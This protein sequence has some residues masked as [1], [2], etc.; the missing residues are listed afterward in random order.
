MTMLEDIAIRRR[1]L[2]KLAQVGAL[3]CA[4]IAGCDAV[5]EHSERSP[6]PLLDQHS[7]VPVPSVRGPIGDVGAVGHPLW[8]SWYDLSA[9][10][11]TEQEYFVSGSARPHPAGEPAPYTT[12]IIVRRPIDASRFNGTVLLDWV[13]VT[14]GFENAVDTIEAEAFFQREGFAYVHV[15][16]Q[17]VGICCDALALQGWDP[18]RYAE[19][20][21]PGD[22]Y[23]F[24]IFS[25]VAQAFRAPADV[26]P[27]QE[28]K[29][30]RVLAMGQSQ[31]ADRLYR[32]V[33]EVQAKSG[34]IDGFLIHSGPF[35]NRAYDVAP[36]VPVVQLFSEGEASAEP[37][38]EMSNYRGW[39]IAGSAH[40][41]FWVGY[42][43][44]N[45]QGPRVLFDAPQQSLAAVEELRAA[46]AN[47]GEQHDS[48][49]LVCIV[50][51][52]QF[53]MRYVVAAALHHL[54]QWVETGTPPPVG[55]RFEYDAEGALVRD[56]YGN[57]R[58]G[59]RLPPMEVPVAQYLSDLCALGG[60]TIPFDDALLR[61][62]Y[63]THSDYFCKMQAATRRSVEAGFLLAED[64]AELMAR[65]AAA[66]NRWPASF[67]WWRE[68]PAPDCPQ[69]NGEK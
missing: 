56:E 37:L 36:T 66:R 41:N 16:A 35:G 18:E 30:E 26:N 47:Y 43:Q 4:V 5:P 21:H 49:Q 7:G 11:Y 67:F 40:Q 42:H 69:G 33:N 29:V 64:G 24:D 58:G 57:V 14:A 60:A 6:D 53:P 34:V 48:L 13:N 46:A 63:P 25:Q 1:G 9:V 55:T 2:P 61:R 28:L 17:P 68:E 20:S 23:A 3:C 65:A 19:L 8:D 59:I 31:S 12:R 10:G 45:G 44:L 15:S 54:D 22:D 27:L 39:E 51:G 62:L 38:Q 50:A 32:Y 52:T